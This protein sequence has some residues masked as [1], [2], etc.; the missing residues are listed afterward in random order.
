MVKPA[1][2]AATACRPHGLGAFS[3]AFSSGSFKAN[4]SF[5][6]KYPHCLFHSPGN[7]LDDYKSKLK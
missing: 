2:R 4:A 3:P 5:F 6:L 1:H 7:G